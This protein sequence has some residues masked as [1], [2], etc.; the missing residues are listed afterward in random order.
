MTMAE[1]ENMFLGLIKYVG[2]IKNEKLKIQRFLSGLTSF[3]KEKIQYDGHRTLFETIMK[4][5]YLYEKGKGR[6]YLQNYWNDKKKLKSNHR[7]KGSK[8]PFN[9]NIPNKNKPYNLLR[10]NPR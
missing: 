9:I 10:M 1:Y 3:Y 6:E 4:A 7:K 5:K 8:P 2:F